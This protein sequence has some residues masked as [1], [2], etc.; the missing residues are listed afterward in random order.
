MKKTIFI[1]LIILSVFFTSCLGP[2]IVTRNVNEGSFKEKNLTFRENFTAP[3]F[4]RFSIAIIPDVQGYTHF[5]A[6][7]WRDPDLKYG[8]IF[9]RQTKFIADHS[10]Q[11]G[12]DF[13]CAIQVGDLV[14]EKGSLKSEWQ[15]AEACMSN[16][17]DQI[18]FIVV[19]GNHDYDKWVEGNV[20]DGSKNYNKYFGPESKFF[21]DKKWYGGSSAQGRNSW[22]TF[23]ACGYDFLVLGMEIHPSD[24]SLEWA[25]K[26]IDEHKGWPTIYVTHEYLSINSRAENEPL[27][28]ANYMGAGTRL[29]F[30]HNSPEE[31]WKKFISNN[32]QIFLTVCGHSSYRESGSALRID[33]NKFNNTTYSILSDY[34][35]TYDYLPRNSYRA[36]F[37]QFCGDGWLTILDFDLDERYIYV[38][39]YSTE[40]DE[41]RTDNYAELALPIDWE[42]D[43][44]F[45]KEIDAK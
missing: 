11:N 24:E 12:G 20:I 17:I 5:S 14:H 13:S 10:K 29:L 31:V 43:N 42:W 25:Q 44:R 40:F 30:D 9:A 45:T 36:T 27:R 18:P 19:P 21:K 16:L 34:Q 23:N 22:I 32:N 1:T 26:I 35:D 2:K 38:H 4:Q 3:G 41:F 7:D 15:I 8:Y 33:K 37:L 39:T 6:Q 28:N